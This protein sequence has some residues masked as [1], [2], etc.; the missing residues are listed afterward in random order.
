VTKKLEAAAKKKGLD[1]LGLWAKGIK[2]HL[3]Y[4]VLTSDGKMLKV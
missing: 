4:S 2:N 3:W 1:D